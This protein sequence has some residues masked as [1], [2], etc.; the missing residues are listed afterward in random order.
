MNKLW[1]IPVI[2]LYLYVTTILTQYG[3]NS[4]FDIPYSFIEV[5]IRENIIYFFQLFQLASNV[6]GLMGWW[7]WF[8]VPLTLLFMFLSYNT[9]TQKIVSLV[10]IIFFI[11][12]LWNS[13]N[14]GNTIA[15]SMTDFYSIP[16]NCLEDIGNSEDSLYIIPVFQNDKAVIIPLNKND[17]KIQGG[18]IVKD[19]SDINCKIEKKEIGN[20]AK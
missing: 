5:S 11:V 18:F 4:Y 12:F 15:S 6:I 2:S 7:M 19:L 14:F 8:L 9:L 3:F 1:S 20:V 10:I 13:Y 17:N 16:E